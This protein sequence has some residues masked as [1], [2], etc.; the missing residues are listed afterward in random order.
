MCCSRK[1]PYLAPTKGKGNSEGGVPK[2]GSFREGGGG[3]SSLFFG[4]RE[5]GGGVPSLIDKQAITYFTVIGNSKQK[6]LFS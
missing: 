5:G 3:L 4:G 1:Y 6:L 2:G